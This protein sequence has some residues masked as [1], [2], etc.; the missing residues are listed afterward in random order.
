M[1][2]KNPH[3]LGKITHIC[4][5]EPFIQPS[6]AEY[7]SNFVGMKIAIYILYYQLEERSINE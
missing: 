1:P 6:T 2:H 5:H 3:K 7:L 4:L